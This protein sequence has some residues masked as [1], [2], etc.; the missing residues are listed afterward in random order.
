MVLE[1]QYVVSWHKYRIL[2]TF[3]SKASMWHGDLGWLM[4]GTQTIC[5]VSI[6]SALLPINLE[7][8]LANKLLPIVVC[9]HSSNE[10]GKVL[11]PHIMPIVQAKVYMVLSIC[12][13]GD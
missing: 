12:Q 6:E 1:L 9:P 3:I 13:L 2:S 4:L 5:N 10:A 11:Y 8:A 7:A